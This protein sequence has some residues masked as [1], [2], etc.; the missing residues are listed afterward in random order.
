MVSQIRH[1]RFEIHLIPPWR[2]TFKFD[3]YEPRI[4]LLPL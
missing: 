4:L 2:E 3:P 1:L